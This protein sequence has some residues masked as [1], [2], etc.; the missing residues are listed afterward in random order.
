[1]LLQ[2]LDDGRLTDSQGRVVN[3]KN[4]LLILTSNIGSHHIAEAFG[5]DTPI[6][7]AQYERIRERVLGD[8]RMAFRPEFLNRLDEIV[9]FRPLNSADLARIIDLLLARL[10]RR[11]ADRNITLMLDESARA[12][13]AEEG[14]D[15]AYGAR[16]LRRAIQRLVENPLAKLLLEGTVGDGDTIEVTAADDQLAFSRQVATAAPALAGA[17]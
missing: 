15:P 8:L 14:Y 16:P 5:Q 9:V 13:I 12:L 1:M 6:D 3:F 17:S 11:L 4:T 10:Y 7:Q 2:I